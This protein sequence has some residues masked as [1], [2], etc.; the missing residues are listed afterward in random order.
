MGRGGESSRSRVV[1]LAE[2]RSHNEPGNCW[3]AIEGKVY[4]VSQWADHP[5]G[6]VI[7]SAAGGDATDSFRAFHSVAEPAQ[8]RLLASM[9]R[10][11]VG[12]LARDAAGAQAL[13]P[14]AFEKEYRELYEVVRRSPE[15]S[16]AK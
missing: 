8:N 5:G 12:E 14:S 2:L 1:T 15:Y 6:R 10:F 7:Y 4:D 3:F 13:A 9:R 11:E 16:K